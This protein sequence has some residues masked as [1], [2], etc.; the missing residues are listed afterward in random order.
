MSRL[1]TSFCRAQVLL[2]VP[3][4]P[5]TALAFVGTVLVEADLGEIGGKK[6]L[7]GSGRILGRAAGL[8]ALHLR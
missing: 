6:I 5:A 2:L 1:G 7:P 3:P 4:S 8:A